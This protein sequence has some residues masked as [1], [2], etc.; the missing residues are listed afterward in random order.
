MIETV[1]TKVYVTNIREHKERKS[2]KGNTLHFIICDCQIPGQQGKKGV[3]RVFR[4][5]V[6]E[7]VIKNGYYIFK[8]RTLTDLSL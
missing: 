6:Y 7:H 5:D 4:E 2:V 3:P 8:E 1:D